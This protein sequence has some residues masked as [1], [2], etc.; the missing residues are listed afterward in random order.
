M[1]RF[2]AS[3]F[4]KCFVVCLVL[5]ALLGFGYH[6]AYNVKRA[7]LARLGSTEVPSEIAGSPERR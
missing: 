1:E 5:L 6:L 4:F 7:G 2:L 3:P